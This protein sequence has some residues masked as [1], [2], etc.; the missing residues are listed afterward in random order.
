[1]IRFDFNDERQSYPNPCRAGFVF[2]APISS[3]TSTVHRWRRDLIAT[4]LRQF[5]HKLYTDE[6][7][8]QQLLTERDSLMRELATAVGTLKVSEKKETEARQSLGSDTK[9]L[10]EEKE[11]KKR[12]DADIVAREAE[13]AEQI[14]LFNASQAKYEAQITAYEAKMKAM[15]GQN[16]MLKT[17]STDAVKYIV[18]PEYRANFFYFLHEKDIPMTAPVFKKCMDDLHNMTTEQL[19]V[20][21]ESGFVGL[22]EGVDGPGGEMGHD[23]IPPLP[24]P[25]IAVPPPIFEVKEGEK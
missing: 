22:L 21:F 23:D 19:L 12:L 5:Q 1:M 4:I 8:L 10:S 2:E 15:E 6:A 25:E 24:Q 11:A 14:A 7:Q 16:K 17:I 13:K 9:S 20:S 3:Q 18:A